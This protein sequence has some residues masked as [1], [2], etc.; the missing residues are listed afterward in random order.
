VLVPVAHHIEADCDR[1]LR[2]LEARG[3]PV[4]RVWG[5]SAIDQ[6]R[7]QMATDAIAQGF[8]ELMWIDS[9][10]AFDPD[11]VERLRSHKLSVVCAIYPQKGRRALACHVLPG[12]K[13]ITFGQGGGL[14]EIQYGAAGFL[15]TQRQVYLDIQER[16][17]LPACN[18]QFGHITIPY[19]LPLVIPDGAGHA[20]LGED[21]SFFERLRRCS[22]RI[23][24]DTTIRLRHMGSYGYSW[25][26]AGGEHPRYGTYVFNIAQ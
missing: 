20:Y 1:A 3:Y 2:E 21:F 10:I 22:Y 23:F 6:G 24:A 8:E 12:T 5:Y 11:D 19:S 26:D 17:R 25:E 14:V 9:D 4:W 13:Q 16:E 18:Q 15:L 7:S